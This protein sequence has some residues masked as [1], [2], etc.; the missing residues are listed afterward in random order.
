VADK[1]KRVTGR[2]LVRILERI[3]WHVDRVRGSHHIMRSAVRPKVTLSVPVH[4]RRTLPI[5]TLSSILRD[6]GISD[7][8][9]NRLA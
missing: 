9:F 4:G 5:G 8:E 6:A 1:L 2:Q 7:E 3:G